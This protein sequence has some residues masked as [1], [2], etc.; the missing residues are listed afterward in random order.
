MRFFFNPQHLFLRVRRCG[1]CRIN[2]Q[3]VFAW[4]RGRRCERLS[5]HLKTPAQHRRTIATIAF[6][7]GKIAFFNPVIS[8]RSKLIDE[9]FC[10]VDCSDAEKKGW[11]TSEGS[12]NPKNASNSFSLNI[13]LQLPIWYYKK[14]VLLIF[15]CFFAKFRFDAFLRFSDT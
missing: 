5:L 15:F 6:P 11:V 10:V 12:E 9:T 4:L 7:W 14:N 8:D 13:H 1:N 2:Y 3:D